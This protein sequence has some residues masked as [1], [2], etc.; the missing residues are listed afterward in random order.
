MVPRVFVCTLIR[1]V[2]PGHAQELEKDRQEQLCEGMQIGQDH[3]H[4]VRPPRFPSH[5]CCRVGNGALGLYRVG[6]RW[7]CARSSC[8]VQGSDL[9]SCIRAVADRLH[10]GSLSS[11]H[12]DVVG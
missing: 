3:G 1:A 8:H 11:A 6:H 2:T 5:R 10:S 9:A 7:R 4:L 12:M